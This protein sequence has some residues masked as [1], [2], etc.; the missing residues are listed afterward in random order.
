MVVISIVH[1][2]HGVI[3]FITLVQWCDFCHIQRG[4]TNVFFL[5]ECTSTYIEQTKKIF[6][7]H[8]L[9]G[10]CL[11]AMKEENRQLGL[12]AGMEDA[13][14]S[15]MKICI[16]FNTFTLAMVMCQILHCNVELGATPKPKGRLWQRTALFKNEIFII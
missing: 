1:L 15:H 9:C 11:E 4:N 6:S 7:N 3:L 13:L 14:L 2:I 8:F 16:K 5:E 10:L 12:K